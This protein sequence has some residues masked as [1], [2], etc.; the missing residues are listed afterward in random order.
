M[1]WSVLY[2]IGI[3]AAGLLVSGFVMLWLWEHV[4]RKSEGNRKPEYLDPVGEWDYRPRERRFSA[5]ELI[6][7]EDMPKHTHGDSL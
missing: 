7:G 1:N 5:T 4:S 3:I 2:C 6:L